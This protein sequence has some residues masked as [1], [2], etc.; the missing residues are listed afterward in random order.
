[1]KPTPTQKAEEMRKDW[2]KAWHRLNGLEHFDYEKIADWWLAK[3]AEREKAIVEEVLV[4]VF[5]LPMYDPMM[6]GNGKVEVHD[7][8]KVALEYGYKKDDIIS[9]IK[10]Q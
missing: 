7:L 10:N 3:M 8:E 2:N 5:S 1:M 6:Y 9:L 4:K